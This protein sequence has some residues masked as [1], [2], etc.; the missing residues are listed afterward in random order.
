MVLNSE[1]QIKGNTQICFRCGTIKEDDLTEHIACESCG[2]H[3]CLTVTE[4][5]DLLNDLHRKGVFA[6]E[7]QEVG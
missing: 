2:E 1:S 7:T 5:F 6:F 4:A 3:A